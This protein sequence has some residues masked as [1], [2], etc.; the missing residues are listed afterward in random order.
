MVFCFVLYWLIYRFVAVFQSQSIKCYLS[1]KEKIFIILALFVCALLPSRMQ[2]QVAVTSE[3][4][5]NSGYAQKEGPMHGAQAIS[6]QRLEASIPVATLEKDGQLKSRWGLGVSA[7]FADGSDVGEGSS[8]LFHQ[9]SRTALTLTYMRALTDKWGLMSGVS[10]GVTADEGLNTY[11]L[12]Y[13]AFC[14]IDYTFN[15]GMKLGL[16]GAVTDQYG[17]SMVFPMILFDWQREHTPYYFHLKSMADVNAT[18]GCR[19]YPN[20]DLT[21][22]LNHNNLMYLDK[23]AEENKESVYSYGYTVLGIQPVFKLPHN[24]DVAVCLGYA[25]NKQ[26]DVRQ[27]TFTEMFKNLTEYDLDGGA[28]V[29]L[30]LSW[31]LG[32]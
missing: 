14:K 4:L 6:V 3:Y 10:A 25:F 28:Y 17:A 13:A 23:R 12:D 29:S 20:I 22:V 21:A 31:R 9:V 26:A 7:L 27:R 18:V 11:R 2:A 30:G 1:V 16:G 15:N 32:R 24:L 19:V 8:E 5:V